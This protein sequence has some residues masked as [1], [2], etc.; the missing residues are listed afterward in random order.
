[1]AGLPPADAIVLADGHPA[2]GVNT[3]R[4]LNPSIRDHQDKDTSG[5]NAENPP[6][7][8]IYGDSKSRSVLCRQRLR[9]K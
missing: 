3:L 5:L 2:N 6:I 4:G 1:V 7:T 9:A 8:A